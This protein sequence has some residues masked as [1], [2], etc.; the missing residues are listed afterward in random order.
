M[1]DTTPPSPGPDL[2][3]A[4]GGLPTNGGP[5][6]Q[7]RRIVE[8]AELPAEPDPRERRPDL[9]RRIL[10]GKG[11]LRELVCRLASYPIS[12]D[13]PHCD[14]TV[15][16]VVDAV[17]HFDPQSDDSCP[18]PE[19]WEEATDVRRVPPRYDRA[20]RLAVELLDAERLP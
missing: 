10:H 11:E 14:R 4:R 1:S 12:L 16:T 13:C 17:L 18:A 2:G 15:T 5:D 9:V 6:G 3:G 8:A 7:A 20:L 19:A